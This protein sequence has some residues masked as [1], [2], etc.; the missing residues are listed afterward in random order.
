MLG[1]TGGVSPLPTFMAEEIALLESRDDPQ[2]AFLDLFHHRLLGLLYRGV[3]KHELAHELDKRISSSQGSWIDRLLGLC[4][5]DRTG[6]QT[7][8]F[9]D[10][11]RV[12]RIA[13]LLVTRSRT[14]TLVA[15]A[16]EV[17][18]GEYLNGATCTIYE[19]QGGWT[20]IDPTGQIRLNTTRLGRTTGLGSR[21]F[22]PSAAVRI[23]LR[24]LDEAGY[25]EFLRGQPAYLALCEGL[26][27]LLDDPLDFEL[28]LVVRSNQ[29][30][31]AILGRSKLSRDAW[32]GH[33]PKDERKVRFTGTP[34]DLEAALAAAPGMNS[35][36]KTVRGA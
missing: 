22:T 18:L 10:W 30:G 24:C 17:L 5:I 12:L 25:S 14:P 23:S 2:I 21:A 16:L 31:S 35:G 4:G 19:Y 9:L 34:R 11:R 33:V 7:L 13:P 32:L 26:N 27:L 15:Q 3:T 28:E 6:G 8:H 1:L 20:S 36:E 29:R